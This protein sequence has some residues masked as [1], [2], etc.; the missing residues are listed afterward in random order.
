MIAHVRGDRHP[1]DVRA[2]R[3]EIIRR[4]RDALLERYFE[5]GFE[6]NAAIQVTVQVEQWEPGVDVGFGDHQ[7]GAPGKRL[8]WHD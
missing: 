6:S 8:F 3:L 4:Q 5:H 7:S 1:H 2:Q